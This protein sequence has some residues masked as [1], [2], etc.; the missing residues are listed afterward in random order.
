MKKTSLA[1]AA[2]V[3]LALVFLVPSTADAAR[4]RGGF[5]GS[6]GSKTFGI[7]LILLSPTGLS[8]ELRL[9]PQSSLDFAIDFDVFDDDDSSISHV[10]YLVYLADLGRGGQVSVPL[11]LGVG[12]VLW[13]HVHGPFDDELHFGLL[14]PFGLALALRAAPVQFFF[15]AA[16]RVLFADEEFGGDDDDDDADVDLTGALGFRVYF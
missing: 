14:V 4:R 10:D 9:S 15:E 7:G 13:E 1:L 5:G 16:V 3:A 2:L 8:M 11:Y 12:A 6:P